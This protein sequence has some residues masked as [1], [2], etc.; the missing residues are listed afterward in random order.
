MSFICYLAQMVCC[1]KTH[2]S[3]QQIKMKKHLRG[4]NC[5][6]TGEWTV[7]AVWVIEFYG[8]AGRVDSE[9]IVLKL[10]SMWHECAF[11]GVCQVVNSSD[12][13]AC[14]LL[15]R[16]WRGSTARAP[17]NLFKIF[18]LLQS[19]DYSQQ[20]RTHFWKRF[21]T[22]HGCSDA[23][24][25]LTVLCHLQLCTML[26]RALCKLSVNYSIFVLQLQ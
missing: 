18:V 5:V 1:R 16:G 22:L 24:L 11:A 2:C 10:M 12:Q 15:A 17:P 7:R 19:Y 13:I 9:L 21:V 20:N 14:R 23:F 3:W 4:R 26:W 8:R 25:Y 6:R